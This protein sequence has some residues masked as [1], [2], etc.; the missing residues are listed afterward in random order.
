MPANS[1][2][3]SKT[4]SLFY[5]ILRV[6]FRHTMTPPEP[7]MNTE[8]PRTNSNTHDLLMSEYELQLKFNIIDGACLYSFWER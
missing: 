1:E 5:G 3:E 2:S 4:V 8:Y 6:N 7:D